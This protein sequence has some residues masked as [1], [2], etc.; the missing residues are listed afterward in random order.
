M[1]FLP[2][3]NVVISKNPYVT[4][5]QS[6]QKFK[7]YVDKAAVLENGAQILKRP[8]F[9][10]WLKIWIKTISSHSFS[11][12]MGKH[13]TKKTKKKNQKPKTKKLLTF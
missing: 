2:D 11:L 7:C 8:K 3:G 5:D 10:E 1:S 9:E 4:F 12:S 13:F 6:I